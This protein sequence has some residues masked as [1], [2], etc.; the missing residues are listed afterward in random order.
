MGW[1]GVFVGL[2]VFV[3]IGVCHPLVVWL[4]YKVG[5]GVWWVLAVVG[6]AFFGLSLFVWGVVSVL[7][8]GAG[9]AMLYSALEVRRQYRRVVLGRAKRNPQRPESYYTP[10]KGEARR[11]KKG[12]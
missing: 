1:Q 5:R 10:T 3:M 6:V 12:E 4:E 11:L 8:G 7:L 2:S 9:A